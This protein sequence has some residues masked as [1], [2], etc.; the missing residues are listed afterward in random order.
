[1]GTGLPQNADVGGT[2][3]VGGMT[4][5]SAPRKPQQEQETEQPIST[6]YH[7]L[8]C[9]H[10]YHNGYMS[11]LYADLVVCLQ[12]AY[13]NPNGSPD[14]PHDA[15]L[16]NLHRIIVIR[17]PYFA[18][19]LAEMEANGDYQPRPTITIAASDPSLTPEGFSIALSSLY[20]SYPYDLLTDTTSTSPSQRSARLRSVL[21]AA[22][23][24]QL[25]DLASLAAAQIKTDVSRATVLEY[26][27]FVSQPAFAHAYSHHSMEIREAVLF[28][29]TK[30]VVRDVCD[31]FG[32]IW[33]NRDGEGYKEL[34]ATFA[35]LPFEWLKKVVES[36]AFEVPSDMERF[37]FAKEIVRYRQPHGKT[38]S[39]SSL[40]L[41]G[42]ENVLLAF[43]SKDRS[44]V[45]IVRRAVR[46]HASHHHLAYNGNAGSSNGGSPN[47]LVPNIQ[48]SARQQGQQQYPADQQPQQPRGVSAYPG[49]RRIWKAGN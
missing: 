17:S 19:V 35:E 48:Q 38:P 49:E 34:V 9:Q 36:K 43:G 30:G 3:P 14:S 8:I 1:F 15:V 11:G 47:G 41:A 45:T 4:T 46:Q 2:A 20:A 28:Y 18:G 42:D 6:G 7:D 25:G 29:L 23:M 26:C 32:M 5:S 33:G 24:L 31:H 16:F 27:Q 12:P 13:S 37:N 10:L 39:T 40:L 21:A 22:T 44:G